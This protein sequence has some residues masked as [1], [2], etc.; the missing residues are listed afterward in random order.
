MQVQLGYST[1]FRIGI[2]PKSHDLDHNLSQTQRSS[3][4]DPKL[5]FNPK[6]CLVKKQDAAHE[7][8]CSHVC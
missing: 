8:E 5:E 2:F 1:C 7:P 6:N 4:E 3:S